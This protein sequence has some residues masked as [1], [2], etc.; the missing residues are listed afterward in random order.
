M[1]KIVFQTKVEDVKHDT[2]NYIIE[3]N[4]AIWKDSDFSDQTFP[5]LLRRKLR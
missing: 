4:E 3:K 2:L 1:F 5:A